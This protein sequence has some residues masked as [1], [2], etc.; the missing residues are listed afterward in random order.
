M[1]EKASCF[2]LTA[3]KSGKIFYETGAAFC[4]GVGT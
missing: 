4:P 3:A 2:P 1:K